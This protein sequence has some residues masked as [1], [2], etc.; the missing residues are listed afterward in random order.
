[1]WQIVS[2]FTLGALLLFI[3]GFFMGYM[4]NAKSPNPP[5]K[6]ERVKK[7]LIW[8][9]SGLLGYLLLVGGIFGLLEYSKK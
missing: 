2:M 3:V 6:K 8:G 7:G 5:S 9:F 1:M 4:T